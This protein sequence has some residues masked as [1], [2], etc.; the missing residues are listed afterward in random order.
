MDLLDVELLRK[1]LEYRYPVRFADLHA[2]FGSPEPEVRERLDDAVRRLAER[3]MVKMDQSTFWLT[4]AGRMLARQ[5]E[6]Q[7][8]P[9]AGMQAAAS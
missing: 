8:S 6:P 2:A 9:E 5:L 1:L 7:L 4:L 3:G